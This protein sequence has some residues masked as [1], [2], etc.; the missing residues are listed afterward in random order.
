MKQQI[1][2][3]IQRVDALEHELAFLFYP[4]FQLFPFRPN[5]S[6]SL[7]YFKGTLHQS[8]RLRKNWVIHN[9]KMLHSPL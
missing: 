8:M 3:L 2:D 9:P 7:K 6:I 4:P 1:K 5:I